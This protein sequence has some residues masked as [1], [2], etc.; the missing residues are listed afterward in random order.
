MSPESAS[1]AIK[2]DSAIAGMFDRIIRRY[3]LM[4]R[5]MTFGQDVGWRKK[6]VRAALGAGY[7]QALDV[8]TGT[9]DLA[10]A[11]ARAGFRRVIGLD[12]SR[13]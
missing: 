7:E 8:A 3:D 11:L 5:V 13:K 10:I 9:G 1:G 4:N 6:A 12:F 2:P